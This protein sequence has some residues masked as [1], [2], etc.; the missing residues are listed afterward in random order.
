MLNYIWAFMILVSV[1]T[2]AITGRLG[3]VTLAAFEGANSAV[4]VVLGF[5]GVTAMWNGFMKIAERSDLIKIFTKLIRPLNRLIFP[6]LKKEAKAMEAVSA[7]MV[8][9]MLGLSNAATPLG[10]KAMKELDAINGHSR[11]ASNAMCMFA[12]INSASIQLIPST[13]IGIRASMGSGAPAEIIVPVWVVSLSAAF[14]AVLA[15]KISAKSYKKERIAKA[16]WKK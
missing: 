6:E 8:A 12:V 2:G 15:S 7:N 9:N 3:D 16:V 10:I 1:V 14:I 13:L 5:M 11:R 4:T